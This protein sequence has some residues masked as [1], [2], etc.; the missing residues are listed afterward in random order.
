MGRPK[1]ELKK[2]HHKKVKKAKEKVKLYLKGELPYQ[3]LT[4]LAKRFLKK[5]RKP[6][7]HPQVFFKITD[8]GQKLL[9]MLE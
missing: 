8:K 4:Q 9:E 1:E 5:R 2:V 7:H 3:K 6:A